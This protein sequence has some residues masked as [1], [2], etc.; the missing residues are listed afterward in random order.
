MMRARAAAALCGV[1]VFAVVAQS[2]ASETDGLMDF[3]AT[4]TAVREAPPG[5]ALPGL[6]LETRV[7]GRLTDIYLAPMD[8]LAQY[9]MSF[10]KGDDVHIVG[11]RAKVA[12]ADVVLAREVAVGAANRKTLY[13]RDNNG[14]FWTEAIPPGHR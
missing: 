7:N 11:S 12:G 14:P 13:L 8:F 1:A 3:Y 5:S 10:Q 4:V 9:G 6:H 2:A